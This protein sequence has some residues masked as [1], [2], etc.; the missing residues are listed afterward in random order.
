MTPSKYL[1][2]EYA[3]HARTQRAF[4]GVHVHPLLILWTLVRTR[5]M[6]ATMSAASVVVVVAKRMRINASMR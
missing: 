2:A 1:L 3:K 5:E 4:L 6:R